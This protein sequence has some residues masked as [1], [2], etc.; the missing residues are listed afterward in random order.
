MTMC[1]TQLLKQQKRLFLLIFISLLAT[2]FYFQTQSYSYQSAPIVTVITKSS[3]KDPL[4]NI[5]SQNLDQL[6]KDPL[7]SSITSGNKDVQQV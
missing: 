7:E 4:V 2:L 6:A 5:I 1:P 3:A